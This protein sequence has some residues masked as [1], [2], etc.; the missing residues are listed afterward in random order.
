MTKRISEEREGNEREEGKSN[1][2]VAPV[3]CNTSTHCNPSS[4][5]PEVL[6]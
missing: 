6:Q 5:I 1:L 4:Y 2:K 3:L